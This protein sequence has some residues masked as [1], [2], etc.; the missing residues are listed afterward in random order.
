[1][2]SRPIGL[3]S[4]I[5]LALVVLWAALLIWEVAQGVTVTSL[6][7]AVAYASDAGWTHYVTYVNAGLFTL[8][9][10]MLFAGLYVYFRRQ[11]P[12]GTAMTIIFC[13]CKAGN[14]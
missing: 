9:V 10:T 1:M 6:E 4:L 14:F 13:L 2:K 8:A 11:A 7:E 3:V 5:T 12:Y